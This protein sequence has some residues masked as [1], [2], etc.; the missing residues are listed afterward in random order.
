M[1]PACFGS[2]PP[3]WAGVRVGLLPFIYTPTDPAHARPVAGPCKDSFCPTHPRRRTLRRERRLVGGCTRAFML[4]AEAA[5]TVSKPL[6]TKA[7][8]RL[9]PAPSGVTG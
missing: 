8:I 6:S 7:C 5:T 1:T 3:D 2:P 4:C 9:A